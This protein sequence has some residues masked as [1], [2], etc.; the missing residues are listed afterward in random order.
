MWLPPRLAQLLKR[1]CCVLSVHHDPA[2]AT[3]VLRPHLSSGFNRSLLLLLLHGSISVGWGTTLAVFAAGHVPIAWRVSQYGQRHTGLTNVLVAAVGTLA[4]MHLKYTVRLA[5]EEYARMRLADSL[6]LTTWEWLQ[7]VASMSVFPPF[8]GGERKLTW[9]AWLLL[10]G[11]MAGHSRLGG[12]DPP[13]AIIPRLSFLQRFYHLMDQDAFTFG[14]QLG[15]YIDQVGA[16]TT[17]AVAGKI[18]VKDNFGYGVTASL[19][20]ALQQVAGIEISA[21]C[22]S[23]HDATSLPSLWFSI[24]PGLSLNALQIN[25][26]GAV[27]A[28]IAHDASHAVIKTSSNSTY[29]P[30]NTTSMSFSWMSMYAVVNASGSGALFI[31]DSSGLST[32]CIWAAIPRSVH[33]EVRDFIAFV[34]TADDAPTVPAPV[35]R[36]VYATVRGIAEAI[37]FGATLDAT[38]SGYPSAADILECLLADGVKAAPDGT[39]HGG[40]LGRRGTVPCGRDGH[41]RQ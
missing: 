24:F 36:A 8:Q 2:Q 38:T 32:G 40:L 33:I 25:D 3:Q 21:Q 20:N 18:Y 41:L 27:L 23:S 6:P 7:G 11:A 5:T 14:L 12:C 35:G 15:A 31:T 29:T 19:P 9:G 22:Y 26:T 4:T 30:F 1:L 37:R 10:F 17:T 13:T 39:V 28:S 34:A 16:H